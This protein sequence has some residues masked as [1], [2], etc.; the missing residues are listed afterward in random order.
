MKPFEIILSDD[1][2]FAAVHTDGLDLSEFAREP[3]II[4]RYNENHV[5]FNNV[6]RH[7][8]VNIDGEVRF[9]DDRRDVC[10]DWEPE[11]VTQALLEE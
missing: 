1:G 2:S 6:T 9:T 8:E 7:W 5:E 11:Y 3:P 10:L 4:A